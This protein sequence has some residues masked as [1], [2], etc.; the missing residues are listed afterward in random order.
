MS[1][2]TIVW[3]H[4]HGSPEEFAGKWIHEQLRLWT[5]ESPMTTSRTT[6]CP[7]ADISWVT[8]F[9]IS[10]FDFWI[11][12]SA[13]SLG[14][15]SQSIARWQASLE[16]ARLE[17]SNEF[18]LKFN[19]RRATAVNLLEV[20][21]SGEGQKVW[22]PK[23]CFI[24]LPDFESWT[25]HLMVFLQW[26]SE[27]DVCSIDEGLEWYSYHSMTHHSNCETMFRTC[28]HVYMLYVRIPHMLS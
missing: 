20:F 28:P 25:I 21:A 16:N 7:E 1:M 2:V 3:C 10:N 13:T 8:Q 23:K 12:N 17:V 22:N 15:T 6:R 4:V 26:N 24:H 5:S 9:W 14:H 11:F 18:Q 19:F 27:N